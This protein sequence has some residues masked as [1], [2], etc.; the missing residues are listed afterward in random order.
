MNELQPYD[1]LNPSQFERRLFDGDW[2]GPTATQVAVREPATGAT[3][4]SIGRAE[5]SDVAPACSRA[6]AAQLAW[7][8]TPPRERA[9]VFQRAAQRL[10]QHGRELAHFLAR[11]TGSSLMKAVHEVREAAQICDLAAGMPLQAQGQLLPSTV[12]RMSIARRAPLGVVA[13]VSPFNFPLILTMR[14]AAPALAVG[15]AVVIKPDERTPVAGGLLTARVFEHAGLPKGVL[16]VLPGDREVG[17]ALVEDPNIAMIAFTGSPAAGRSI[18][19][20]AGRH[21]K[22][23][24]LELGGSNSLIILDDADLETAASNAAWGAYMHQGQICMASNRILVQAPI[25]EGFVSRL[26]ERARGLSVG[27]GVS[28]EHPIGPMIDEGQLQRVHRMVQES[29]RLGAILETGG[30]FEGPFYQPTVL[31]NV[32]PGMPVF[33]QETFGP[34]ANVVAFESDEEAVALAN[35]SQGGLAAGIL[36]SSIS[37]ALPLSRRLLRT[38]MVHINDQTI[39]DEC[40]NPFGGPGVAGGTSMGGPS[41]WETYTQWQWLTLKD[42]P[43]RYPF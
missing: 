16:Q 39:N 13:V 34:V 40:V 7:A 32:R 20:A 35:R 3:L 15:N 38:G 21:L 33:D 2:N 28:G 5:V 14:S 31:T 29:V 27:D 6:A 42:S 17:A 36:T 37:R 11:E 30:A 24:A 10:R 41:D 25:V 26:V 19:Q 22:R 12:G 8:E 1:F 9:E 4:L 18:A 43:T 23:V